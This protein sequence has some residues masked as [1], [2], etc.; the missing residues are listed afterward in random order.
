MERYFTIEEIKEDIAE[1]LEWYSG[2][3]CDLHSEVF[4]TSYYIVGAATAK[5]ALEQYGVFDAIEKM[6]NYERDIFGEVYTDLSN[7]ERVAN[8]P[9]YV[10]GEDFMFRNEEFAEIL[11]K[12]WNEYASDEVNE[13]LIEALK[14][15]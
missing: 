11:N 5:K 6:Q 13:Q 10:L 2:Y 9:Y 1:T 4:N 7:P 12:Y 3:Y 14:L 8:M 15:E